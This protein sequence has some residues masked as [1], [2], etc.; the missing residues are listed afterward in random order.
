MS[1]KTQIVDTRRSILSAES[2]LCKLLRISPQPIVRN[3]WGDYTLPVRFSTGVPATLLENRP[4]IKM[5]DK[6]LAEA[7]Y[8]TALARAQFF[9]S[10][11]L[12]GLLGWIGSFI[13]KP[14]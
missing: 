9:P 7:F 11:S 13:K 4:D 10:F 6:M 12:T 1:V 2:E 5:A 8:N 14:E 3:T